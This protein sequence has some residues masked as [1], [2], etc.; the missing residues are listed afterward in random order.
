MWELACYC[1]LGLGVGERPG[2]VGVGGHLP[3]Y[4]PHQGRGPAKACDGR[5]C[6]GS[7]R[8]LAPCLE[9]LVA[10]TGSALMGE[11]GSS[12]LRVV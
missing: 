7:C 1:S 9:N 2:R 3:H 8:V 5:A 10:I 4:A 12:R 6:T 11:K